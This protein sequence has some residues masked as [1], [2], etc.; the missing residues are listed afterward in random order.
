MS[1]TLLGVLLGG[2][3]TIAAQ[4][5][6]S[7][8]ADKQLDRQLKHDAE[9]RIQK[10]RLDAY[11]AFLAATDPIHAKLRD[12]SLATGGLDSQFFPLTQSLLR[13]SLKARL[14]APPK[15]VRLIIRY[16]GALSHALMRPQGGPVDAQAA[17]DAAHGDFLDAAR[18]DVGN[19]SESI[20]LMFHRV[21]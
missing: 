4:L 11:E 16:I 8:R 12:G 18:E 21:S 15:T 13:E 6:Q 9:A 20:S 5:A 3:L 19:K 17:A 1:D 7:W 2:I 10:E 14:V